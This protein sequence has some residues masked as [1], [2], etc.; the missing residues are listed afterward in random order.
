VATSGDYLVVGAQDGASNTGV[1]YVYQRSA[2]EWLH[3]VTLSAEDAK[4]GNQFGSSVAISGSDLAV[5]AHMGDADDS[6]VGACY[7]F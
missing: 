4:A 3:V 2:G 6:D 1:A 7:L 5:G